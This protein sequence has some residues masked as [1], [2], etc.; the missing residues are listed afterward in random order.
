MQEEEVDELFADPP[1]EQQYTQLAPRTRR[2]AQETIDTWPHVS[3][4]VLDQILETLQNAKNDIVHTQRDE[5]RKRAADETLGSLIRTLARQL[6]NSRI[7]PQAKDIFFNIG[8]LNEHNDR[9]FRELTR[10][11][12]AKQL[13]EEQV[14]VALDLVEKDEESLQ[15]LK[16]NA[17]DWKVAWKRQQKQG[18]VS[19]D[20]FPHSTG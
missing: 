2:I 17:K 18:Q 7:P 20:P 3:T 13:L 19:I 14:K 11:R 1:K 4:Q 12:H 9:L 6:S 16:K 5:H 10:E 15:Q 8:K